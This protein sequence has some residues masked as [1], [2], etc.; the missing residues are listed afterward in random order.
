MEFQAEV[1]CDA[2]STHVP[3]VVQ[4]CTRRVSKRPKQVLP[5]SIPTGAEAAGGK[6]PEKK[7]GVCWISVLGPLGI[8]LMVLG[9]YL[10]L[11]LLDP[12]GLCFVSKPQVFRP[13]VWMSF[14][15]MRHAS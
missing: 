5:S 12:W 3:R 14:Y 9:R 1:S 10:L 6:R 2:D 7:C 8:V 11:G 4:G 15:K 13:D